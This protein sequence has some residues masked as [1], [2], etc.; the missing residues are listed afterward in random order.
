MGG[1]AAFRPSCRR[2]RPGRRPVLHR[3][4][5]GPAVFGAK[6]CG[7][8]DA[9]I[10]DLQARSVREVKLS[11][12]KAGL[13]PVAVDGGVVVAERQGRGDSA[14]T[15]AGFAR[16]DLGTGSVRAVATAGSVLAVNGGHVWLGEGDAVSV[17]DTNGL[18]ASSSPRVTAA[19]VD[20][21]VVYAE[22]P[23]RLRGGGIAPDPPTRLRIGAPS[24]P[25]PEDRAGDQVLEPQDIKTVQ[26]GA[27]ILVAHRGRDLPEGGY[28]SVLS[29]CSLPQLRCRELVDVT[30]DS[31]RVLGIVPSEL[32]TTG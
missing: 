5:S 19:A 10:L 8:R 13:R 22:S 9:R 15:A 25:R 29:W 20:G 12:D 7:R 18:T 16:V 21:Q 17:F 11:G 3:R 1:R 2:R 31:A 6:D 4:A 28:A 24:G 26:D 14:C 32:F 27:A 23:Y 30:Q